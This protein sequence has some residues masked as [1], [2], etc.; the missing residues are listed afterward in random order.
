MLVEFPK[1]MTTFVLIIKP[2]GRLENKPLM[3]L[4]ETIIYQPVG[5]QKAKETQLLECIQLHKRQP[6]QIPDKNI[7]SSSS[8]SA[9]HQIGNLSSYLSHL[10]SSHL[11]LSH[12]IYPSSFKVSRLAAHPPK[13]HRKKHHD[14]WVSPFFSAQNLLLRFEIPHK[15]L[16]PLKVAIHILRLK[17]RD[18]SNLRKSLQT[19]IF[20][21]KPEAN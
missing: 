19:R 8:A 21:V 17:Y 9:R 15:N 12:L 5:K 16:G 2:L 6:A 4:H 18:I 1:L 7:V 10:I 14:F 11:I 20:L 13:K 3:N